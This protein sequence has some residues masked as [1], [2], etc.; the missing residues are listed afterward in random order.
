MRR[1]KPKASRQQIYLAKLY[2]G[3]LDFPMGPWYVDIL[4]S[5]ELFIEYNGSGHDLL[6]L[7]GDISPLDQKRK[8]HARM[9][10]LIRKYGLRGMYIQSYRDLL[11]HQDILTKMLKMTKSAIKKGNY[12]TMFNVDES[13]MSIMKPSGE[14]ERMQFEYG[15]LRPVNIHSLPKASPKKLKRN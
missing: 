2:G 3:K 10:D 7:R 1:K 4:H 12:A 5:D 6:V 15:I 11:P 8:D 13:T 14:I 9:M